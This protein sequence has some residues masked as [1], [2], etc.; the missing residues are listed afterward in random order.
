DETGR[1]YTLTDGE[2]RVLER[3]ALG[4]SI[5]RRLGLRWAP[6]PGALA[7]NS[8]TVITLSRPRDTARQLADA[9][10][11]HIDQDGNFLKIS[12]T[13]TDPQR[14]AATLNAIARQYVAVADDL[15][16]RR[17]SELASI[18]SQQAAFAQHSLSDAE[19][20]YAAFRVRT[21]TL[22]QDRPLV[23]AAAAG[24]GS[25]SDPVLTSYFTMRVQ[26]DDAQRQR[27]QLQ[28]I[29]DGTTDT[30][31]A[32][33]DMTAIPAVQQAPALAEA[34]KE[35]TTKSAELR[36]LRYRYTEAYPPVQ[37]LESEISALV[38]QTIPQFT[39]DAIRDLDARIADLASRVAT[40]ADTLRSAPPRMIEEARLLRN[41]SLATSLFNTLQQRSDEAQIAVAS[42]VPGVRVLD[43]AV[44]PEW[45]SKNTAP[46]IILLA[47]AA[48]I[49]LSMVGAVL[50]DRF[51]PRFRYPTQLSHELGLAILGTVPH[52]KTGRRG[53]VNA[54]DEAMFR[55]AVRGIRM[56]LAYAH[57]AAGPLVV[58]VSSPGSADGKSF[59][60]LNLARAFAESGRRTLLVDGDM[61]R[62]ALHRRCSAQRRPG[63]ADLLSGTITVD[64][65]IQPTA[66]AGLDFVGSGTRTHDAPELL[67]RAAMT[68]CMGEFRSRYEV[69]IC[70]SP[71]LVA[72]IDPFVLAAASGNLLLVV[73]TGVSL[74]DVTNVKL[75]MLARMPVR[76]LG[77]VLND[78][79]G[80]RTYGYYSPYLP[81]YETLDEASAKPA[82]RPLLT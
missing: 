21:I 78:V 35:L 77:A 74:R 42:T 51:D 34:V 26:L 7:A 62:G 53:A 66:F 19:Q 30:N 3:G 5:G 46:R 70:D 63:L 33:A 44:P 54:R 32:L 13:D 12:L 80:G 81:G 56:N 58:T 38:R 27:A 61:R 68:Q 79:P 47:L 57:G 49:A 14:A 9:L 10:D 45:P 52:L 11:I 31:A 23:A 67:G 2:A 16:R 20:A 24:G 73:R 43:A 82:L 36:A 65:A 40:S 41:V 60:S 50:V 64:Q 72:G 18:L 75:E 29:L 22:P 6:A 69:I 17:L 39:R 55:E 48:G 37:R 25:A 71:P 28:H 76:L 4:D 59:L 1:R 8:Q 15:R